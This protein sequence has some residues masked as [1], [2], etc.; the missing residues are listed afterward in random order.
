MR[1]CL[2]LGRSVFNPTKNTYMKK[3]I[4]LFTSLAGLLMLALAT[5]TLAA[6]KEVTISGKGTCAKCALKETP[7]CQNVIH[8]EEDGKTANYYL[9]PNTITKHFHDNISN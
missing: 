2:Y 8:A 1:E 6:D 7:K 4:A 5:P 3:N 9:T